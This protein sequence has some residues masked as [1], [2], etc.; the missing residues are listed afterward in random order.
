M[1]VV[2]AE[3]ENGWAGQECRPWPNA[4][5]SMGEGS[6]CWSVEPVPRPPVGIPVVQARCG[7][8]VEQRQQCG[9]RPARRAPGSWRRRCRI[10]RREHGAGHDRALGQPGR[11]QRAALAPGPH[12]RRRPGRTAG[13]RAGRPT[14]S[15][16]PRTGW[17][18]RRCGSVRRRARCRACVFGRLVAPRVDD[19]CRRGSGPRRCPSR[20]S[21]RAATISATSSRAARSAACP[22]PR[23]PPSRRDARTRRSRRGCRRPRTRR[24][25]A[26]PRPT[27]A[28]PTRPGPS[29]GRAGG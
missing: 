12:R 7:R 21:H 22:R 2:M 24:S 10:D 27:R 23:R 26:S 3:S 11:L 6:A 20:L 8:G 13:A 5:T 18:S 25:K 4:V 1:A 19:A 16:G 28:R 15:P 17:T 14:P 29:G 9:D